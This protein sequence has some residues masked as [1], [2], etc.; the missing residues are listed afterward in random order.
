M[1]FRKMELPRARDIEGKSARARANQLPYK[2]DLRHYRDF[3]ASFPVT[4]C[5]IWDSTDVMTITTA[6][7]RSFQTTFAFVFIGLLPIANAVTPPP[8]GGYPGYNT[9]GGDNALFNLTTGNA[10]TA[11]GWFALYLLD[12]G[13]YNTGLGAGA[14]ALNVADSNTAVGA[15]ALWLNFR[16]TEN[17]AV[18][19]GVLLNNDSGSSNT[20]VGGQTLSNNI[21]G[22]DNTAVGGK[23]LEHSNADGSTAVGAF[24]LNGNS[25][26]IY[27]TAVGYQALYS[28]TTGFGNIAIGSG[29]GDFL[30]TGHNNIDVG[31]TGVSGESNTIRIGDVGIHE[32]IFLAG[33][34]P[35]TAEAPIQAVLVDPNTGQLGSADIGS[36]PEGPPGPAGPQGPAGPSGPQGPQ[37]SPGPQ[38]PQGPQGDPGPA[39]PQGSPG[40]QG[41]PGFGVVITAPQ[42]TAVG[43][44]ALPS[45][46]GQANTATGFHSLFTNISGNN[47]TATGASALQNNDTGHNNTATGFEALQN[48]ISPNLNAGQNNTAT[49]SEA[50]RSNT[51]GS[52]NTAVGF[53]TLQ[54][55]DSGN[56]NTGI[57]YQALKTNSGGIN[58]TALG[59]YAMFQATGNDNVAIGT[60]A[61]QTL[62]TGGGN[63]ALG[64]DAGSGVTTANHTICIGPVGANVENGCFISNIHGATIPSGATVFVASNGQLGTLTSSNR[65]KENIKPMDKASEALFSLKPV[66]FRYKKQ[67]DPAGIQQFGLVAEEVEKV[68]PD[69]VSRDADGKAYT[70]RYEQ[71]N[72]MLLNE[73]L[74]EHR[75][76]EQQQAAIAQQR[77]DFEAKIAELKQQ[78]QTLIACVERHNS[79]IQKINMQVQMSKADKVAAAEKR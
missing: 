21:A 5:P 10:N 3:T 62:T 4:W 22:N 42:N 16:G 27:N 39:G 73:F 78:V 67:L 68:D 59:A 52:D 61:L 28:N 65:F 63:I 57:G 74:K 47:N 77:Q 69:L 45:N 9:A 14:L 44:Q 35:M 58:N 19:T 70:V 76:V 66:T 38:G 53:Q 20:A 48:N 1:A 6:S 64:E 36:F 30:T 25:T 40:P 56:F 75:Q 34:T 13:N 12:D 46:T 37:G 32:L 43:D 71:V 49:G 29:A 26:G 54:Q 15:L 7:V 41:P 79:E 24:A 60:R 51:I 8:N 17:T 18:G 55:N 50:M 23:A 31:N 11:V 33:I 2:I 72:A